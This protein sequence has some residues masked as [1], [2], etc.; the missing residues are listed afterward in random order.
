MKV[1]MLGGVM[2]FPGILV[3]SLGG[4][5]KEGGIAHVVCRLPILVSWIPR[6]IRNKSRLKNPIDGRFLTWLKQIL[7]QL[8]CGSMSVLGENRRAAEYTIGSKVVAYSRV[9]A[10]VSLVCPSARGKSQH[11]RVSRMLN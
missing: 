3:P 10:A 5:S 4:V 2:I 1:M 9:R 6:K 8:E 11:Q 7:G